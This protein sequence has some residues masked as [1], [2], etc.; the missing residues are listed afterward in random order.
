MKKQDHLEY[1]DTDYNYNDSTV[2]DEYPLKSSPTQMDHNLLMPPHKKVKKKKLFPLFH[3][4]RHRDKSKTNRVV[5]DSSLLSKSWGGSSMDNTPRSS[6]SSL[7]Q[8]DSWDITDEWVESLVHPKSLNDDSISL[9]PSV[10][11]SC[12]LKVEYASYYFQVLNQL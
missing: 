10:S 5:E 9:T 8:S 11:V 6:T 1:F 2:A 4:H 7:H 3:R 12:K